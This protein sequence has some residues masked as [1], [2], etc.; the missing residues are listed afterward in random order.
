MVIESRPRDGGS[1]GV[2]DP[3]ETSQTLV[4]PVVGDL[5]VEPTETFRVDLFNPV[6][7]SIQDGTGIGFIQNDDVSPPAIPT[8]GPWVQL[9]LGLVLVA[10]ARGRARRRV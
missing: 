3:F 1:G 6:N 9:V 2:P 7:A 5:F 4:V 8:L 10:A